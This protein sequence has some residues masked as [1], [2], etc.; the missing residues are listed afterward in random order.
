MG[1]IVL[2][3]FLVFLLVGFSVLVLVWWVCGSEF[4]L[5]CLLFFGVLF[6]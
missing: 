5:W 1:V 2:E 4:L 3:F 6:L